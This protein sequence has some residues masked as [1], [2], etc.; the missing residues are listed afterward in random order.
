M[1]KS[2]SEVNQLLERN[3]KSE[4]EQCER[5]NWPEFLLFPLECKLNISFKCLILRWRWS[6][7]APAGWRC[8][9]DG[10]GG[11]D[12]RSLARGA[13]GRNT[14]FNCDECNLQNEEEG[15]IWRQAGG[16]ALQV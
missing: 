14:I 2:G 3:S 1:I 6:R 4:S 9:A 7:R 10:G 12:P 5:P 16:A 13:V 11:L 15:G 8:P